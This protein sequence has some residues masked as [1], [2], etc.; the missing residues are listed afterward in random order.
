MCGNLI[1]HK[2]VNLGNVPCKQSI[3]IALEQV[4]HIPKQN[5][6]ESNSHKLHS[7]PGFLGS[8][9]GC[10]LCQLVVLLLVKL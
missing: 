1:K 6:F 3:S 10:L 2:L 7:E 5:Y 9:S 8:Q 4:V